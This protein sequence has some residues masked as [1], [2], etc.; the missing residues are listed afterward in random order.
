M[1]K[2]FPNNRQRGF[3]LNPS[4]FNVSGGGS[5][6]PFWANVV[7]LVHANEGNGSSTLIDS[8]SKA[9]IF[10]AFNGALLSNAQKIEGASSIFLDG[11]ND[12]WQADIST[13][14]AFGTAD[15]T[16]EFF[17]RKSAVGSGN[18]DTA[19][20]TG[21]GAS[22]I[23][24]WNVDIGTTRGFTFAAEGQA[25]LSTPAAS[26]SIW[27]HWAVTRAGTTLRL[28]KDGILVAS[29]ANSTNL[30]ANGPIGIGANVN[31]TA[32]PFS[33]YIDEIRITKGVARYTGNFSVP[34]VPFPNN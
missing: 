16:I 17:S 10:T 9:H 20:T 4:R 33:G 31:R 3:L 6:D 22:V 18:F 29:V 15:F 23:N 12:Y 1:M 25:F 26:D 14:F 28:F 19:V 5:S 32:F 13:D 34:T 24:S 27:H 2:H 30:L 7:L 11:I 8:S 21:T